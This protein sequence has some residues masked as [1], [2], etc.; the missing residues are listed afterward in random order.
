MTEILLNQACNCIKQD[1]IDGA[2]VLLNK[3]KAK[4]ETPTR[5]YHLA[6]L[7][8]DL[9][10]KIKK[11]EYINESIE[12][13]EKLNEKSFEDINFNLGT[14]Y[15]LKWELEKEN[16]RYL[17][18]DYEPSL[19]KAKKL[20]KKEIIENDNYD[21]KKTSINL[22]NT[23]NNI[24]RHIE[25]IE[26][27]EHVMNETGSAYAMLNK[28]IG[29]Y[30][31][32]LF[33][34]NPTPI[35]SEAYSY[36]KQ[37]LNDPRSSSEMKRKAKAFYDDIKWLFDENIL[38]EYVES[39]RIRYSNESFEG[40]MINFC[41]DYKLFLNLDNF[42]QLCP[43]SVGDTIDIEKLIIN[44]TKELTNEK[45]DILSSYLNQIKMDF[46]SARFLLILSQSNH[47]DLDIITKY[48]YISNTSFNEEHDI[49]IQ[50]LKDSFNNF[51]NILD[52]IAF[53]I[54]DYLN[55]EIKRRDVDFRKVW[56]NFNELTKNKNKKIKTKKKIH[57]NLK[58]LNNTGVNALYDIYLELDDKNDKKYLR[59]TRNALTHRYL[60][61]THDKQGEDEKTP[62]EL[63][64]E[65]IEL[66]IIVKNAIIYLM[67]LIKIN[68]E[69]KA[70]KFN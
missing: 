67:S 70:D 42:C 20:L 1:D 57:E 44:I 59:D 9:G 62:E 14:A 58:N 17:T 55:L 39:E 11:I 66:S 26:Y 16:E 19:L 23:Y 27:Y 61:I 34:P 2:N 50:L 69:Y 63:K 47:F 52:K 51:F 6:I 29:L 65:T 18:L 24:G 3:L 41:L 31:Y 4:K 43:N 8:R 49:R 45:Y 10:H 28:G 33:L 53:F 15:F 21:F 36:F 38:E 37:I 7:L 25:A 46:V 5:N 40:F 48:T 54:N 35:L 60:R 56:F 22:A 13:F 12:K 68:E 30:K 64:N 32:S